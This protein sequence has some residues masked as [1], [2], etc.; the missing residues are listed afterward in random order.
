[1]NA[2]AESAA[3]VAL[4]RNGR[5]RWSEYPDLIEDTSSALEIVEREHGLLATEL[6]EQANRDIDRWRAQEIEVLT[7]LDPDY[8]ENL[9]VAHDRPPMIF[10]LGGLQPADRRAVAVIGSRQASAGGRAMAAAVAQ[11]LVANRYTVVSG[12]AVGVDAAAHVAALDCG[13]RTIA[14]IGTGVSRC[15]PPQNRDLQRRIARDGA[16]VSQFWPDVAPARK[17]FLLRNAVMS[18]MSLASVL[19]E[20]SHKSGARAQARMALAQGRPV[21]LFEPLLE[22]QWARDLAAR[23]ATHVVASPVEVTEVVERLHSGTLTA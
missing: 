9:R 18:G 4:H 12:L 2:R 11:D 15:Y 8:P 23:P 21:V 20:A 3:V 1:M 7:L 17:N 19:I 16:V 13:G 22:Q 14:V 10:V 6:V 5:R